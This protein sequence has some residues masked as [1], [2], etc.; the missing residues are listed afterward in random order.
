MP[1][2]GEASAADDCAGE[3]D[4]RD[5]FADDV[6]LRCRP[7][8]GAYKSSLHAPARSAVG[9]G[10]ERLPGLAVVENGFGFTPRSRKRL[11]VLISV[12]RWVPR[13]HP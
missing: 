11:L 10:L 12:D 2:E 3:G 9:F 1:G 5:V 8:M 4:F 7:L 13:L 6:G